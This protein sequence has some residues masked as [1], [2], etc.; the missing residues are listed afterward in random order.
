MARVEQIDGEHLR[1]TYDD[2]DRLVKIEYLLTGKLCTIEYPED[3]YGMKNIQHVDWSDGYHYLTCDNLDENGEIKSHTVLESHN[4]KGEY[5]I[6]MEFDNSNKMI[7]F[8][9]TAYDGK[10]L[11]KRAT[12]DFGFDGRL[13]VNELEITRSLV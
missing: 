5:S 13:R 4:P 11:F 6:N 3:C 1:K 12:G 2:Q 10:T 7:L 8:E 9:K